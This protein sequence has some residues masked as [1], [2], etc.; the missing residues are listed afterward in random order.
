M[1][2]M[3][4]NMSQ[5]ALEELEDEKETLHQV[6]RMTSTRF[7]CK[8]L[9]LRLWWSCNC[10]SGFVGFFFFKKL[11]NLVDIKHHLYTNNQ[12]RLPPPPTCMFVLL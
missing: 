3:K 11:S 2:N 8:R 4:H 12:E 5:K 7:K 1:N 6:P 10:T 9:G